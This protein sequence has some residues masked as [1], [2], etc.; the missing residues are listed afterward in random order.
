M[1]QIASEHSEKHL[2]LG[3]EGPLVSIRVIQ[4]SEQN[5]HDDHH[6]DEEYHGRFEKVV[7]HMRLELEFLGHLGNHGHEGEAVH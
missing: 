7:L 3:G 1:E 5:E 4:G 6:L 2:L